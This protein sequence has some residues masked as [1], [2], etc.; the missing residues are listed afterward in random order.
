[1]RELM[2]WLAIWIA[3]Q[4]P[5]QDV[6]VKREMAMRALEEWA[7]GPAASTR[8]EPEPKEDNA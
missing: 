8:P 4:P 5:G 2:G 3:Y 6:P 1:M 7:R